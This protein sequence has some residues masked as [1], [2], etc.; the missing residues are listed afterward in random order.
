M[1]KLRMIHC[2]GVSVRL[3]FH[4][5]SKGGSYFCYF[6]Y[7]LI[8]DLKAGVIHICPHKKHANEREDR[9]GSCL[10]I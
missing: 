2:T 3:S 9:E 4:R 1:N 10:Y 8:L 5:F 7:D 6:S